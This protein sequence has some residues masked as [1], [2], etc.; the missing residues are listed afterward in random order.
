MQ[1][2]EVFGDIILRDNNVAQ[3]LS[4]LNNV[5]DNARDK[6]SNMANTMANV[7]QGLMDLGSKMTERFTVPV[8]NAIKDSINISSDLNEA[9]NVVDVTFGK[10]ADRVKAWSKDLMNS[11]GLVQLEAV[12]YVGS[13]GAMLKSSGFTTKQAEEMSKKLVELTGDMSSFYNLSHEETWE[14]IRSGISG[15][16][17]PLKVLGINM[18]VANLEAYALSQ[19]INKAWKEMDQ[20]EQTTLR[21]NYL[22]SVTSD[23]QGDFSRT[24]TSFSNKLR[25]ISGRFTEMK[26]NLG[27]KL[28][29]VANK[30]LDWALQAVDR[31]NN[32]SPT[33]QK[34]IGI[35]TLLVAA[36]GPILTVFGGLTV[37]ISGV[38]AAIAAISGPMLAAVAIAGTL[39]GSM[40]AMD[41]VILFLANKLG[42]LKLAFEQ[43]KAIMQ[44]VISV[45]QGDFNGAM[46]IL[47][48]KVGMSS[49]EAAKFILKVNSMKTALLKAKDVVVNIAQLIKTIYTGDSDKMMQLLISKFGYT[50]K[51]AIEFKNKVM[52]LKEQIKQFASKVKETA[53][54]ALKQFIEQTKN[55]AKYVYN[56][57]KEIVQIIEKLISFGSKAVA[58]GKTIVGV[59]KLLLTPVKTYKQ[60]I[61]LLSSDAIAK[62]NK[63]KTTA[64]TVFNA[65]SKVVNGAKT[66]FN[67]LKTAI[68]NVLTKI[69]SIK[70]P[71]PP[72]WIPGFASG[73]TNYKG[74]LALVGEKGPELVKLPRGSDVV[75]NHAIKPHISEQLMQPL[76][77]SYNKFERLTQINQ[78]V[79]ISM[80]NS[81]SQKIDIDFFFDRL[82]QLLKRRGVTING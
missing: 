7:G 33:I 42:L 25:I 29:P 67:S 23:S 62:L 82:M 59:F 11:F 81:F 30:L 70:F 65:I 9:Y 34:V 66:A 68:S 79:N 58:V 40:I 48:S 6:M 1:I 50:R 60:A 51:E 19:G 16:T 4:N 41:A 80:N 8:V 56:H 21:Y 27:N 49:E 10:N 26:I 28:L 46:G 35:F 13:M 63:I 3:A 36:I 14:K 71:S 55:A 18:S 37:A 73:V 75:P 57:R 74:G 38:I 76:K 39:I 54:T 22:L 69:S 45:V 78:K 52:E 12:N 5:V 20:A 64:Q 47:T 17:E 77:E 2:F 72:S 15:E 44:S 43:A 53:L 61:Q 24:S 32:L 31:F